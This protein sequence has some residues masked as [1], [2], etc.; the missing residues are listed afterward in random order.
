MLLFLKKMA[1]NLHYS[2]IWTNNWNGW[3]ARE[4][5]YSMVIIWVIS[6][7]LDPKEIA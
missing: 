7:K 1:K 2:Q 6:A 4:N 3:D 5:I